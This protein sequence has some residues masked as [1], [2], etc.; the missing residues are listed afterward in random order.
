[1]SAQQEPSRG[2]PVDFASFDE[3][4]ETLAR[5]SGSLP[6]WPPTRAVRAE[7]EQ[8]EPR[9]DR[10]RRELSRMLVVG[11]IGGT[12]TGKSTLVNAL[13]GCDLSPAGDIARP[14]TINPVVVAARDVDLS[15][16]PVDAMNARATAWRRAGD[17]QPRPAQRQ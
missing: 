13:A 9:L 14:T 17:R 16:L 12:G 10:A 8:I 15:W 4:V 6:E 2:E 11:V 1:M 3:L 5:W 7:W